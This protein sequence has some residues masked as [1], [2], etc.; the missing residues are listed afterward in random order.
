MPV[1]LLQMAWL[2]QEQQRMAAAMQQQQLA[3]QM[4][5]QQRPWL[6]WTQPDAVIHSERKVGGCICSWFYDSLSF[7]LSCLCTQ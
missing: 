5:L 1:C 6:G 7:C 2:T 3:V 4:A